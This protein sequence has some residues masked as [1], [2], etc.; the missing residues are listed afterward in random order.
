MPVPS[1]SA[2][3]R[4]AVVAAAMLVGPQVAAKATR[5]ALFL[6]QFPVSSLPAMTAT[7][8]V[9]SLVGTLAFSRAM[10][11][12][13]PARLLPV[14]VA[15]SAGL[16]AAEWGLAL[17]VPRTAAVLLY[18]HHALLAALLVSGFWSLVSESFDPHRARQAMGAIGTGASLGGVAGG[19][20]AWGIAAMAGAPTML[21][22]LAALSLFALA[23]LVPLIR[24]PPHG[25]PQ[26]AG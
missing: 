24:V 3:Y 25:G 17:S 14:A 22:V 1:A 21:A 19:L 7:A 15:A 10:A 20:L 9:V 6:S 26:L 2:S 16:F 4:P 13:S 5:D 8:A 12:L 11:R 18:L 23:S